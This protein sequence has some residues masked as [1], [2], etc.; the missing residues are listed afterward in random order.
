MRRLIIVALLCALAA[1]SALADTPM[2]DERIA[3]EPQSWGALNTHDPSIFKDG[4]MYY[5]F[6]TDA[7]RGDI[8]KT[9]VQLRTSPDLISWSYVGTA[10]EDMYADCAAEVKH[11]RL[12]ESRHDGLWAPDVVKVGDKYRLYYSASTFGSTRSCIALAEADSPLGPYVDKGIVVKSNLGELFGANC[13]DPAIISDR[14][15][16]QYMSYGSFFGGI[17]LAELGAD[18]FILPDAEAVHIAGSRGSAIEGSY[19]VYLAETDYYYLFV[20]YG[21]LSED[22]NVRVGR[23]RD[24]AGPYIDAN[25]RPLTDYSSQSPELVG[26]KLLGCHRFLWTGEVKTKRGVK[27]PGHCSVLNDE[28]GLFLVH[29]ARACDIDTAWFMLQVR[30]MALN[31]DGWPVVLPMTY[32]GEALEPIELPEGDYA[33]IRQLSDSNAEPHASRAVTLRGGRI[34]GAHTGEYRL[35]DGYRISLTLDGASYDGVAARQTDA[36]TGFEGIG[37]SATSPE[38]LNVLMFT[39]H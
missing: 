24:V 14:D 13:I 18:G 7:S 25:G 36:E 29:H 32:S 39:Q 15:G 31:K 9:G 16:R 10:F 35:Y 28:N 3:G 21:S 1:S 4:D 26:T 2:G 22:Y 6:S 5:V 38:G 19:I 20:S 30:R 33:L 37:I 8:H 17:M 27:A 12:H 23:S 34:T 11:A